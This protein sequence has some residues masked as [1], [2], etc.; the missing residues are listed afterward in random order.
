MHMQLEE[1]TSGTNPGNG[2]EKIFFSPYI[3]TNWNESI[4][5]HD[6]SRPVKNTNQSWVFFV[7]RVPGKVYSKTL[8]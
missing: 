5:N 7:V 6:K 4:K 1:N 3:K 2:Y 8:E